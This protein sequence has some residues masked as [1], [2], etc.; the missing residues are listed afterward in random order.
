MILLNQH[1]ELMTIRTDDL[2][3]QLIKSQLLGIAKV[4]I[5]AI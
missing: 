2:S 5:Y 1:F 3:N 4:T